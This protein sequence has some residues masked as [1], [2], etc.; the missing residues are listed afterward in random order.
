MEYNIVAGKVSWPKPY[1]KRMGTNEIEYKN[2]ILNKK[3]YRT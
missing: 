2:K 1:W 3:Y